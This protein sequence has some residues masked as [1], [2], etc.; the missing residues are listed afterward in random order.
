M[1]VYIYVC[2]YLCVSISMCVCIYVCLLETCKVFKSV[3]EL[4]DEA[5]RFVAIRKL[6]CE[7]Y[8]IEYEIVG[9]GLQPCLHFVVILH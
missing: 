8:E 3:V 5:L 2:L 1:C 4:F 9:H 7:E 6:F